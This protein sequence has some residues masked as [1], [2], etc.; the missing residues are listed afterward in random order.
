[1][2]PDGF[3]IDEREDSRAFRYDATGALM[4]IVGR[5]ATPFLVGFE[6]S[7]RCQFDGELRLGP[8][9]SNPDDNVGSL[10][11]EVSVIPPD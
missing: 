2:R 1:M 7:Y 10:Q 5:T 4:G 6:R 8:N 11:V 3:P 9:D